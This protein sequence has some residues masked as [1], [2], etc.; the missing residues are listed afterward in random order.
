MLSFIALLFLVLSVGTLS[1]DAK[2]PIT[3]ATDIE[4]VDTPQC[5]S[6][7]GN[8]WC[9]S[10]IECVNRVCHRLINTSCHSQTEVCDEEA[11]Q[12]LPKKCTASRDC[13]DGIFC[14]GHEKCVNGTCQIGAK[15]CHRG[16]C[17][18]TLRECLRQ[19][20]LGHWRS[21][22]ESSATNTTTPVVGESENKL[23]IGYLLGV[24]VVLIMITF[25]FLLMALVRR[26]DVARKYY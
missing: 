3:V 6:L 12:C 9:Q 26:N 4:C 2:K 14:N 20:R 8:T 23:W 18:E 10:G 19:S 21:Y 15:A 1:V 16:H 11:H 5:L 7:A 17:N 22:A 13:D 24:V 25:V